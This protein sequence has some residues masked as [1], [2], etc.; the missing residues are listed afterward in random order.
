MKD[1]SEVL[2]DVLSFKLHG[3]VFYSALQPAFCYRDSASKRKENRA[4]NREDSD[5]GRLES[6]S[7]A[8]WQVFEI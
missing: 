4:G 7:V 1:V 6:K 2:G 3:H 8:V 5:D